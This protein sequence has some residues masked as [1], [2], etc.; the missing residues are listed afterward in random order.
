[1]LNIYTAKELYIPD[2]KILEEKEDFELFMKFCDGYS[3]VKDIP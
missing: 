1:M 2:G 3:K